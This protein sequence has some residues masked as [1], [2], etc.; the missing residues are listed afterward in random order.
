MPIAGR[1]LADG[2]LPNAEAALYTAPGGTITYVKSIVCANVHAANT[3]TVELFVRPSGGASRRIVRV[4][5]EP[6]EQ[7]YFNAPLALDTGDAIRG[8][9]TNAAEIDY[10][11]YGGEET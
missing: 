4:P 1:Q 10:T 6:S 2:Q 8:L 7:L 3:N 9:A 11:I 5:L